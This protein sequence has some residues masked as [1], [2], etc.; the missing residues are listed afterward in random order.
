MQRA[1]EIAKLIEACNEDEKRFIEEGVDP[2]DE[3]QD[4]IDAADAQAEDG[5]GPG[6]VQTFAVVSRLSLSATTLCLVN[7]LDKVSF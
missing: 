7:V 2:V 5:G 4:G 6:S 3:Y 1:E